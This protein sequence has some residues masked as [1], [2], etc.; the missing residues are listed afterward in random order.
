MLNKRLYKQYDM[1]VLKQ[2]EPYEY[3]VNYLE[4]DLINKY[5]SLN[6]QNDDII[7]S[8][9]EN[10][11]I[12]ADNEGVQSC[13]PFICIMENDRHKIY[14]FKD[15][16]I[17]EGKE[18]TSSDAEK[19]LLIQNARK[20]NADLIYPDTDY[21][22]GSG[23]RYAPFI[24]PDWS[25]DT[26][27][28]YDYVSEFYAVKKKLNNTCIKNIDNIKHVPMVL[29]HKDSDKNI[30][31]IYD[32]VAL[33]KKTPDYE[34]ERIITDE[35]ISVIIPSKDNPELVYACLSSLNNAKIKSKINKNEPLEVVLVDNGSSEENQNKITDII[36]RF[37]D[38]DVVYIYEKEDFNYSKMCNTGVSHSK[39][40]YLL[41]M[42]DDIEV[43]DDM[44]MVKLLHY[45][46]MNHVGAVSPKL[47]Y[48]GGDIIQHDGIT[49]LQKCGPTHKMMSHSD[50]ETF[51]YSYN[52]INRNVLAVTGACLMV[53]REK[54]FII[55][56]FRDKMK[57]GYN[58][59]ELCVSLYEKGFYNII[60]NDTVLYHHESVTR[61]SDIVDEKKFLRL[62][63][64]R[65]LLYEYHPFLKE[66]GDPFY[67]SLLIDDTL[68]YTINV[69]G[70][71]ARRDYRSS[72]IE[73]YLKNV[74]KLVDKPHK[75]AFMN[76]ESTEVE[77]G[78]FDE[79]H[80]FVI[81]GWSLLNKKDN[82]YYDRYIVLFDAENENNVYGVYSV[83]DKYRNDVKNVFKDAK[84]VLLAGFTAKIP[85]DEQNYNDLS[86]KINKAKFGMLFVSKV[87]GKKYYGEYKKSDI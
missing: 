80:A 85:L 12:D 62:R 2:T 45:A 72:L 24:K 78:I 9:N 10:T 11:N 51:Y 54:Y 60:V 76:V 6:V 81:N 8:E 36:K 77:L 32:E 20:L 68:D 41:F 87:T 61:G 65:N 52:R 67:S 50:S 23:K 26:F 43:L 34:A 69:Y 31:Q 46:R 38:L 73:K 29:F 18:G 27:D 5:N 55:C 79:G 22:N 40:K 66:K 28:S 63:G 21:M 44:F 19:R 84:N 71:C 53:S 3:Y 83:A 13:N 49:D 74:R 59:V 4:T 15:Y 1:E 58:D 57:V 14:D 17:F 82:I 25:P 75:R 86:K 48:P 7:S 30:L 47:Y 35:S 16:L 33:D 42:N 70:D 64:E 39:G 56:G 37:S